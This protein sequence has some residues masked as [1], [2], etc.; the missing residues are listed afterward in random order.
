[1]AKKIRHRLPEE[2]ISSAHAHV[3]SLLRHINMKEAQAKSSAGASLAQLDFAGPDV[4]G[5]VAKFDHPLHPETSRRMLSVQLEP[6]MEVPAKDC[7]ASAL[8]S[9]PRD[10]R[11]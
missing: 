4:A 6:A 5:I 8:S 9:F 11:T 3:T 2:C 7:D 10:L 1:M